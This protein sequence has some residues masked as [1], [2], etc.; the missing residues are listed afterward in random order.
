[1]SYRA[2]LQAEQRGA[3]DEMRERYDEVLA[4]DP[5]F[6]NAEQMAAGY[7]TYARAK[8]DANPKDALDALRRASR[9][10]RAEDTRHQIDSLLY[11]IEARQLIDQGIA[12]QVLLKRAIELDPNNERATRTWTTIT[13]AAAETPSALRRFAAAGIVGLIAAAATLFLA[14]RARAHDPSS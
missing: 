11:A 7:L 6:E 5:D 4:K 3:L 8:A 2:G 1:M 13:S 9:L 12:D 10:I 14:R